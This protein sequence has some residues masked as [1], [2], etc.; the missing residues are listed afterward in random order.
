MCIYSK[1]LLCKCGM[2]SC[3]C[4]TFMHIYRKMLLCKCGM[5]LYLQEGAVM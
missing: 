4:N 1:D 2:F 3:K 5:F